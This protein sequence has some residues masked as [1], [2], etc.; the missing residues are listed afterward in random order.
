MYD[1]SA[2]AAGVA[3]LENESSSGPSSPTSPVPSTVAHYR[4]V[5]DSYI[6]DHVEVL[7]GYPAS[8]FTEN[9]RTFDGFADVRRGPRPRQRRR[10]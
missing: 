10:P 3:E 4:A 6:S 9:E 2:D 8:D 5:D 7:T 1:Q